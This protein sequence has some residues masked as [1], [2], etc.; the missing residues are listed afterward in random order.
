MGVKAR[1]LWFA[2]ASSVAVGLLISDWSAVFSWNGVVDYVVTRALESQDPNTF[3]S[4]F[5]SGRFD[6]WRGS[7]QSVQEH[8]LFGL[9][10]N[11]YW[12][13]PNRIT[14]VQPH[15]FLVQFLLE[16]GLSGALLFLGLLL[17]GFWRGFLEHVVRARGDF[18][19]VSLSAGTVIVVLTVHGLV[20]GTYYHPQPSLYLALAFAI[21]TLPRRFE[22]T[23]TP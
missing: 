21:W 1:G 16:W 22:A 23:A 3:G 9:G 8:L 6:I 13:M 11:G 4:G 17:Y 15:S 14:G 7:W 10:P 19:V 18:D 2:F 20:D 5:E 12:F